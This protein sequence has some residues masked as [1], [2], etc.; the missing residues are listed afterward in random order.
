MDIKP[1]HDTSTIN[2][3]SPSNQYNK[4]LL[5]SSKVKD[6][7]GVMEASAYRVFRSEKIINVLTLILFLAAIVIVSISLLINAFKPTLLSEKLIEPSNTYYFFGGTIAFVMLAKIISILIDLR[8]LKNSEISYRNEVQRGDT[9]NGPQYMKNAYKKII[10]RQIDHNWISI[11]LLWF[12]SIFL[13]ILYALKDVNKS[14]SLGIF[15]RIDFNFKE[16]IRI[17]FGNANLVITIFIIVL[18]AW[19]VLHVFFALSRKKRKN[20]IEQSFGG[21]ENWI[22]DE[23]YEKITKGRRKIW[24]RIFLV[25]NFILILVPA[26]F[27]FWRWMKNRRKR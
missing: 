15:G 8:N 24:F 26:L 27:L 10:L 19:V 21:K 16:L 2:I 13:G 22:T 1:L 11:I 5:Q 12:C 20:D 14:V 23:V 18:A 6:P 25:I 9:P 4:I 3:V 7:K 17:M